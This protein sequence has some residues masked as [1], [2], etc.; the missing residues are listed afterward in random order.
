[1][2]GLFD[3]FP[4]LAERP[5]ATQGAEILLGTGG[6]GPPRLL[7]HGHWQLHVC[8][9]K[10]AAELASRCT[11]VIADLRGYGR[12]AAPPSDAA[13]ETDCKRAMAEDCCAVMRALGHSRFI[14]AGQKSW[15][16]SR[17]LKPFSA[18]ALAHYRGLLAARGRVHARC[19]DYRAGA[20]IDRRLDEA[21]IAAG[22]K[23]SCPTFVPWGSAYLTHD[24]LPT[25]QA[26]CSHVSGAT[27]DCGHFL[28]EENPAATLASGGFPASLKHPYEL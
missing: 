11:L 20:S 17:D 14:V 21:D 24:P 18:G 7:L 25:W 27:V 6:T 12:S 19:K 9:H 16:K 15:S 5:I 28:A 10:L 22:R 13:H 4:G 3:L 23:I 1:M 8:W 26:W 2:S